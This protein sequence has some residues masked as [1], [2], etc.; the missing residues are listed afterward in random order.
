LQGYATEQSETYEYYAEAGDSN[1]YS[2]A[3]PPYS[4]NGEHGSEVSNRRNYEGDS[5]IAH[6][7]SSELITE[8]EDIDLNQSSNEDSRYVKN[9]TKQ[10]GQISSIDSSPSQC[11]QQSS[12]KESRQSFASEMSGEEIDYGYCDYE[13]DYD[14]SSENYSR[15]ANNLKSAHSPAQLDGYSFAN[16]AD[17]VECVKY[18]NEATGQINKKNISDNAVRSKYSDQFCFSKESEDV[19]KPANVSTRLEHSHDDLKVKKQM[20]ESVISESYSFYPYQEYLEYSVNETD[21]NSIG[22]KLS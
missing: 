11:D 16:S 10:I 20:F 13:E 3:E 5:F 18:G 19:S 4:S 9:G 15:N 14:K 8:T 22:Q 2:D 12:L 17:A 7:S 1:F 6:I 21:K